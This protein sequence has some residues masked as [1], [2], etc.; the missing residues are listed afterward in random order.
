[1]ERCFE[2]IHRIISNP[3]EVY[4]EMLNSDEGFR[5][6]VEENRSKSI[7][8]LMGELDEGIAKQIFG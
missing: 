3:D 7:N 4:K 5:I 6:F 2:V 8:Q 1:M